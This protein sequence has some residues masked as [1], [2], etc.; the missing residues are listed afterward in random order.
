MHTAEILHV[1]ATVSRCS[2]SRIWTQAH[3]HL[4]CAYRGEGG[5]AS[6]SDGVNT[7]HFLKVVSHSLCGSFCHVCQNFL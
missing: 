1:V 2:L 6:K 4:S 3:V 5:T 7:L